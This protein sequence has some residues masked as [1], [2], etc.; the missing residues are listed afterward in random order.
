M[1]N[2]KKKLV[3]QAASA[4]LCHAS[5]EFF[6]QYESIKIQAAAVCTNNRVQVLS[7]RYNCSMESAYVLCLEDDET[8]DMHCING[9]CTISPENQ[10]PSNT[11]L[12]VNGSL[13]ILPGSGEN[14]LQYRYIQI[15]GSVLCPRSLSAVLSQK[16]NLNGSLTTYPDEAHLIRGRLSVDRLFQ[17]RA[18][19]GALYYA[20][21][22]VYML[23]EEPVLLAEKKV[24]ILAGKALVRE[25]YLEPAMRVLEESVAMIVVP[26]G[27]QVIHGTHTL[28]DSTI[29]QHGVRL[30]VDGDLMVPPSSADAL[31][32]LEFLQVTGTVQLCNAL[33]EPFYRVCKKCGEVVPYGGY[34]LEGLPSFTVT[35]SILEL[36]PEGIT[37]SGCGA[38]EIPEDISETLLGERV[39]RISDCGVLFCSSRAQAVLLPVIHDVGQ[40]TENRDDLLAAVLPSD[41]E[42]SDGDTVFIRAAVYNA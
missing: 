42:K 36:H 5:E 32:K 6:Q 27:S 16:A 3:I 11:M 25:E 22:P 12:V 23:E 2:Q 34:T 7:A 15:N 31:E 37:I 9:S 28:A 20:T 21:G 38:V 17:Y 35:A 19:P 26:T 1:D 14:L 4:N 10:V 41:E 24:R 18:E 29:L 39:R 40:I 13:E 30:F 33:Q 8:V